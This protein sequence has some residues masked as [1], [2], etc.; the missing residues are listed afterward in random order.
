MQ[1]KAAL[2]ARDALLAAPDSLL[3]QGDL[4]PW[5]SGGFPIRLE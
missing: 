4:Q 1:P 3:P 5:G 2:Q